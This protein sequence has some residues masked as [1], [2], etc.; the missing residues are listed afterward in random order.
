MSDRELTH[1]S[2]FAGIGGFDLGFERAG[3]KTVWQVEIDPFCRAVLEKHFP[4][5]ER[6]GDITEWLDGLTSSAEAS[7]ARTFPTLEGAPAWQESVLDCGGRCYE[8]FA[9]Y[10]LSTQ[11]WRTWQRCLL[12]GWAQFLGI[13]PRA[14]MTRN[15]IA[16]QLTPLALPTSAT[17]SGLLPTPNSQDYQPICWSRVER[18]VKGL[19]GRESSGTGGGCMNLQD[20]MAAGWMLRQ[21]LESRPQ[22]GSMP[23]ANPSY[24]EFLMGFPDGWTDSRPSETRSSRKSR[25]GSAKE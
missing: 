13:W 18:L 7:H 20:S 4:G 11:L 1:G 23:R 22:R 25:S 2:L 21:K 6:H 15:G 16:Y 3:I 14:G 10:D 8:P 5:A 12:E 24:W 17:A 19:R 9:W